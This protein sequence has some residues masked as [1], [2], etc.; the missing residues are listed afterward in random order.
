MRYP[1]SI[2]PFFEASKADAQ[3]DVQSR[4]LTGEHRDDIMAHCLVSDVVW[5]RLVEEEA[6]KVEPRVSS[7]SRNDTVEVSMFTRVPQQSSDRQD[8]THRQGRGCS[9]V[10]AGL[11]A[12]QM[13]VPISQQRIVH[14]KAELPLLEAL[15]SGR[16][17][18]PRAQC[19]YCM[20]VQKQTFRGTPRP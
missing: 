15:K 10:R 13:V 12:N 19:T 11:D 2:F 4:V 17:D 7:C 14:R 16:L 8:R 20:Y 3:A 6:A 9:V 1:I 5:R 18:N